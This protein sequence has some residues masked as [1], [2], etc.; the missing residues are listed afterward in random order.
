[1]GVIGG[2]QK[3]TKYSSIE[4][5]TQVVISYTTSTPVFSLKLLTFHAL[6]FVN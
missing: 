1:M 2:G 4:L 3:S 6:D 5:V